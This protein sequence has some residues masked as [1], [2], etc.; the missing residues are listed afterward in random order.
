MSKD[1]RSKR[2]V[3]IFH[4][5]INTNTMAQGVGTANRFPSLT[6]PVLELL[7]KSNVGI[8]QLPCPEKDVLGLV[9]DKRFRDD[10]P[11][12]VIKSY[13]KKLVDSICKEIEEYKKNGFKILAIIGKQGSPIC[14]VKKCWVSEGNLSS[15]PGFF[16]EELMKQL[17]IK[18]IDV[19]FTDFEKDEESLSI[20][21]IRKLL[22]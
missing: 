4:C 20:E 10:M 18:G 17:K 12:E 1:N 9:R 16:M 5:L 8:V 2:I 6:T 19:P 21:A 3:Y 22:Q 14:G 11:Q 13:I 7:I 15:E